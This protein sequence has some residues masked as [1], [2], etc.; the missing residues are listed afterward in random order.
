VSTLTV[1]WGEGALGGV[2]ASGVLGLAL[3]MWG[4][5]PGART[6]LARLVAAVP[7]AGLLRDGQRSVAPLALVLS[8]GLGAVAELL[9]ARWRWR[10][11]V[12]VVVPVALLPS[13]AWGADGTLVAA[14]WPAA[15]QQVATASA[16]LPAGPV[17]VLPWATE[18]AYAWNGDRTQ[19][20]PAEHWLPRR[21]VGDD[22]LQVGARGTPVEDPLA[23]RIAVAATGTTPLPSV[24]RRQGYAGVLLETDQPG[25]RETAARLTGLPVARSAPGL[26]L[27]AVPG[28]TPTDI[29]QAP[30]APILLADILAG[31]AVAA[32]ITICVMLRTRTS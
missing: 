18:R 30:L 26:S 11:A 28:R 12:L 8:L 9:A 1:G 20:D 32:S 27:Y 15:W 21:V 31:L 10:A 22:A 24:L 29:P 3:A 23:R 25:A 4:V 17:L 6:V 2:I 13:A 14:D 7:A 19:I 16:A 5:T